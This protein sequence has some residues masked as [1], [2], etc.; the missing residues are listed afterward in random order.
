MSIRVRKITEQELKEILHLRKHGWTYH[1][2]AFMYG[3][4]HSSVYHLCK[5]YGAERLQKEVV[6][7]VPTIIELSQSTNSL[8]SIL[9]IAI[10]PKPTSYAEYLKLYA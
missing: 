7:D 2:L 9:A 1:S 10:K 5:K 4:D 3:I 8:D 6:F